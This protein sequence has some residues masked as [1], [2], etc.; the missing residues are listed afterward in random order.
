MTLLAEPAAATRVVSRWNWWRRAWDLPVWAHLLALTAILLLLVP[1]VGTSQSFLADEGAAMIQAR[2]LEAGDGWIVEHP[3]PQVDP[4]GA[5]YPVINAEHGERGA[6]PLAKH[7]AYPLLAA[8]AARLGGVTGIVLLS[9]AGTIAAAGLAAALAR[10][11]DTSLVRPSVWV[12]GLASPMLFDGFLAMA[13]TLGAALAAA[14]ILAAVVSVQDRRPAVALLVIPPVAGAVLLRNEALLFAAALVVVAAAIAVCRP[15]RV[16]A[17]LVAASALFAAV[18]ARLVERVWIAAITGGAVSATAVGV[19]AAEDSFV[20]GRI[21]G[22]TMTWLTPGYGGS[23]VLVVAMLVM[24]VA[25]AWCG[26]RVRRRP[27]DRTGIVGSAAVAAGAAV[28]ALVIAPDNVVPGLLFAFP[29]ATAG[30]VALHRRLFDDVGM[31]VIGATATLFALAVI[32]TQYSIGGSGEWGG[33]YFA[34]VIPVVVPLFLAALRRQGRSLLPSVRRYVATALVVCSVALSVMAVNA[35][36]VSHRGKAALVAR[37]EEAGRVTG[38]GRPVVVTSW[39]GASRVAW[40]T[41]EDHRWLYVPD[42]EVATASAR[43]RAVGVER[44]VFVASEPD[45]AR[46]QLAGLKI[47][48]S[49]PSP[50]ARG[51]QIL[52]LES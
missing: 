50:D 24:L 45:A 19:P 18:G 4:E 29:V 52:V 25:V 31:V 44:F 39:I 3:L 8:A 38:D 20:R 27:D 11:I 5:W 40:P 35:L 51:R 16:P 26:L 41:F 12:V 9:L 17:A 32:A 6:A 33:R 15:W 30:M 7:P 13:H 23:P 46:R 14:A 48:A 43:L 22:F 37:I 10:R 2:S 34:L 28:V 36:R 21:D 49:E 1:V 42:G 47:I